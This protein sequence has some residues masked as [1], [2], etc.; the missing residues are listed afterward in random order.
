MV[1]VSSWSGIISFVLLVGINETI[2]LRVSA[3]VERKGLDVALQ[4]ET[5]IHH[6]HIQKHTSMHDLYIDGI[7]I[8][9]DPT[10]HN[11]AQSNPLHDP[12]FL[13]PPEPPMEHEHGAAHALAHMLT[14]TPT[15]LYSSEADEVPVGEGEIT[16]QPG[17]YIYREDDD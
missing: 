15:P 1:F 13:D 17:E 5:I 8:P 4:G 14:P 12:V 10:Q 6:D 3:E 7:H 11:S 2:G 16:L 9:L